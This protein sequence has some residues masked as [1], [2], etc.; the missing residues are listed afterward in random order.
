MYAGVP[1]ACGHD[2]LGDAKIRDNRMTG[3]EQDVLGLDVA[4]DDLV[5]VGVAERV[6]YLLRDLE[7]V[8]QRELWLAGQPIAERFPL[9]VRHDVI[10]KGP[11]PS[12]PLAGHPAVEQRQAVRVAER[13]GDL[14][15]TQ[16]PLGAERGD[17][18]WTED[19]YCHVA[20]V[21][22]VLGEVH[23][24]HAPVAELALDRVAAGE[25]SLE[26]VRR[27]GHGAVPL[28]AAGSSHQ[29]RTRT[30]TR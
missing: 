20:V 15:F 2:R 26:A 22:S 19:L 17:D 4:M 21:L 1:A 13:G 24:G 8:V 16:K 5:G 7:G 14:D 18:F 27:L 28:S 6:G 12:P 23:R 29:G 10:K 30:A 9:H 25:R 11:I 3:L